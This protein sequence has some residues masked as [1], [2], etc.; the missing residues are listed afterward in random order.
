MNENSVKEKKE[1]TGIQYSVR[2]V[3]SFN[4]LHKNNLILLK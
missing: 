4:F 1:D 2:I 3:F